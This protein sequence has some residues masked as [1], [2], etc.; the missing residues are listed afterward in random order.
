MRAQVEGL[1]FAH[2]NL[3]RNPFGQ[4]TREE[5][6]RLSIVDLRHVMRRL[7]EPRFVLQLL[8]EKG[9]GK[10]TH[11]LAIRCRFSD[12]GY[13]HIAEGARATLPT[14]C[15]LIVDEAQR[16]TWRQVH[17]LFRRPVPLVL[18]THYDYSPI[19]AAY[20]RPVE[21]VRVGQRMTAAWLRALLNRRIAASRREPGATPTIRLRTAEHLL[22]QHGSDVRAILDTLYV[23]F[24]Q[25]QDIGHV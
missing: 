2:L 19:V 20:G 13:V 17:Q 21:T 4:W 8:G 10:T 12:A 15:P 9:H 25:L 24:Q 11:A 1:P 22:E 14:G 3:R 7:H 6:M 5:M 16:L 23:R 18:G